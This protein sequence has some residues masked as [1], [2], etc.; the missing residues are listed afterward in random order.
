MSPAPTLDD[1]RAAVA[2]LR[3][4]RQ[5]PKGSKLLSVHGADMLDVIFR[6][7]EAARDDADPGD[8][9]R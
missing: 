6:Y 7:L 3:E 5:K 9:A 2:Y 4:A 8:T 1:A